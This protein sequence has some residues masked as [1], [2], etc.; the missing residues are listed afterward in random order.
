M[1]GIPGW[2]SLSMWYKV[3]CLLLDECSL[4]C[5]SGDTLIMVGRLE[6]A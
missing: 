1:G 4:L 2:L 5:V 6:N 3:V